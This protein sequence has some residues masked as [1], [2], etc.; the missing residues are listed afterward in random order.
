MQLDMTFLEYMMNRQ[1]DNSVAQQA[2]DVVDHVADEIRAT[3]QTA[4]GSVR[5]AADVARDVAGRAATAVQDTYEEAGHYARDTVN[6]SLARVRSCENSFEGCVRD[7]PKKSLLVAAA[8][9]AFLAAFWI[10]R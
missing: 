9:G 4:C 6:H 3:A 5:S 1:I 10:R 8:L 7:N 2:A